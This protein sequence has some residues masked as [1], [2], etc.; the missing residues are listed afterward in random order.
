MK[1]VQA[2]GRSISQMTLGTVQLGLAYGIANT[3]G[4]PAESV[5]SLIL[6]EAVTCGIDGFDTASG[7][8]ESERLLG[9]FF[10]GREKPLIVSKI[11]P[12]LDASIQA[13][14]MKAIIRGM[15][16]QSLQC[17]QLKTLPIMMLHSPDVLAVHNEAIIGAMQKLRDEGK[18]GGAGVSFGGNVSE[19]MSELWCY[20]QND[21]FKA[22]QI[23]LNV[24]DQRLFR[25]GG[26]EQLKQSGK[27]VFV[28]SVFLQGLLLMDDGQ[29]PDFLHEARKPLAMLRDLAA[30]EG[31]SV[32]QLAIS[33]VRDLDFVHSLVIGAETVQQVKENVQLIEGPA[34]SAD[35]RERICREIPALSEFILNPHLW[36]V[37]RAQQSKLAR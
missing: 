21:I 34:L 30:Q 37:Y 7:Y 25:N 16:E 10:A 18:I 19:E 4:K 27:I 2:G 31:V 11:K 33:F 20:L 22:V 9:N 1:Y 26:A 29:I 32:A 28:R 15:V 23:P 5:A 3:S 6:E 13:Q 17:L 24:L 14:E 12:P 8:G 36:D 35:T